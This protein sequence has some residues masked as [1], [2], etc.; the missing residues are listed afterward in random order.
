MGIEED[1]LILC[2]FSKII[3]VYL[4]SKFVGLKKKEGFLR[5]L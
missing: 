5:G 3:V 2:I 4:L 1:N